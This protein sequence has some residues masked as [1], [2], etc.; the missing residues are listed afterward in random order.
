M[1]GVYDCIK[2]GLTAI[3]KAA[4]PQR[5]IF[6]EEI[7]KTQGVDLARGFDL[8]AILNSEVETEPELDEK[9]DVEDYFFID[10]IP[11]GAR[12]LGAVFT[13]YTI[14]ID[15][16]AHVK[17]ES[18]AEYYALGEEIDA[19]VRPVFRFGDRAVTVEQ[20]SWRVVDRLLHYTFNFSFIPDVE[21]EINE[22][23]MEEL[24]ASFITD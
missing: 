1:P 14:L 17:S 11:A 3:L 12:T 20:A 23:Y 4:Y 15:I 21:V 7:T 6:S 9:T 5:E 16:A 24:E 13:D 2:D 19:L 10:I 8:E 18:N 22:P